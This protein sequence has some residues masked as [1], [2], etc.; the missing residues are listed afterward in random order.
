MSFDS[1]RL[2]TERVPEAPLPPHVGL[3]DLSG[4]QNRRPCVWSTPE[5]ATSHFIPRRCPMRGQTPN[6]T[7]RSA[8]NNPTE[9]LHL[10]PGCVECR[11][12]SFWSHFLS[13]HADIQ[14]DT[15]SCWEMEMYLGVHCRNYRCLQT[16]GAK[17]KG[18]RNKRRSGQ[19]LT[20]L[21]EPYVVSYIFDGDSL[22]YISV[23]HLADEVQAFLGERKIWG[24]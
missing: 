17:N 19:L 23:Q 24:S 18:R 6:I 13:S 22:L 10:N 16:M 7:P 20:V 5:T 9:T 1:A 3:R 12:S 11:L 4:V 21:F 15:H 14:Y 2:V 8:A